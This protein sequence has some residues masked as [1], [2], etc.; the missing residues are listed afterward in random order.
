M[1]EWG[2]EEREAGEKREG[3]AGEVEREGSVTLQTA[4]PKF[5]FCLFCAA[6]D[7]EVALIC[8][9]N[10]RLESSLKCSR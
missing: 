5:V 2:G 9:L 8:C 3:G 10:L 6:A 7:G 1:E 4:D